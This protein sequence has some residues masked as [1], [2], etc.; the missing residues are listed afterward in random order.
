[1]STSEQLPD[2]EETIAGYAYAVPLEEP[3][4]LTLAD[5]RRLEAAA[6]LAAEDDRLLRVAGEVLAPHAG[7][8]VDT[9]RAI[10]RGHPHL[11]AY[12]AHPDG[13]PNPEYGAASRPRFARWIVDVCTRPRD[14]AWL[15]AQHEIGRRHTTAA[16]NRTD[17]ADSPPSIPLRY[18][19]A[20]LGPT[21]ETTRGFLARGGHAPE[22]VARMHAAWSKAVILHVTVWSRAYLGLPDEW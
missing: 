1:M 4:P 6:G 13:T 21:L 2:S 19:L 7:E 18:V 11:A 3:S 8:M 20:F 9:F 16:K 17:G 14:Q 15:D 12:A 5:L 22:E 10:L